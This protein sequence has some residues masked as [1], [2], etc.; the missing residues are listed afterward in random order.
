MG[1]CLIS[2]M[3]CQFYIYLIFTF[4]FSLSLS[5]AR[6]PSLFSSLPFSSKPSVSFTV[7]RV[8]APIPEPQFTI[9]IVIHMRSLKIYIRFLL[10]HFCRRRYAT[11]TRESA[12]YLAY[13]LGVYVC[14]CASAPRR[15]SLQIATNKVSASE[16]K[17][18]NKKR[19]EEI[20]NSIND[21]TGIVSAFCIFHATQTCSNWI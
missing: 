7:G 12:A 19:N 21:L 6:S 5:R 13:R 11:L 2:S 17:V 9:R 3:R 10:F 14:V 8:R 1:Y 4:S 15:W 18:K 20:I 16:R